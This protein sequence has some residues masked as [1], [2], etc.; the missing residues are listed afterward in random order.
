MAHWNRYQV[1]RKAELKQSESGIALEFNSH[2]R[3][4]FAIGKIVC[5]IRVL[6][7]LSQQFSSLN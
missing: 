3:I 1:Q 5:Y 4:L 6:R 7:T 2:W